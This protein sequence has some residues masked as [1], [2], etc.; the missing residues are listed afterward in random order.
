MSTFYGRP[1]RRASGS[2]FEVPLG[3]TERGFRPRAASGESRTFAGVLLA[4]AWGVSAW[5][6]GDA[7]GESIW[8]LEWPQMVF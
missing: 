6:G 1:G 7:L 3:E 8:P 5:L 2:S 4:R